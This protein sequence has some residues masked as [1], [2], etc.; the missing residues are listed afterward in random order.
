MSDNSYSV[1]NDDIK[2]YFDF[3]G[4]YWNFMKN[5][6]NFVSD[7]LDNNAASDRLYSLIL[8]GHKEL[9][10]SNGDEDLQLFKNQMLMAYKNFIMTKYKNHINNK[11]L[12]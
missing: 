10:T 11:L 6:W 9:E 4:K 8:M 2:E 5:T 12:A 1:K 7:D 3:M